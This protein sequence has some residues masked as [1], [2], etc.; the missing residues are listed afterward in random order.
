MLELRVVGPNRS[1]V[2]PQNRR[3][4]FAGCVVNR[5]VHV[6]GNGGSVLALEVNV[7]PL[8]ELQL[9]KMFVVRARDAGQLAAGHGKNFVRPSAKPA[10]LRNEK[11]R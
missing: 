1:A 6:A 5:L 2:R 4:F 8:R 7:F 3:I 10:S 9:C 11:A